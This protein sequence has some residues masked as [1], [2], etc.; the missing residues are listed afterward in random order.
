MKRAH[1]LIGLLLAAGCSRP[2]PAPPPAPGASTPAPH[3]DDDRAH[4]DLPRVIRLT[5]Q[6][7]KD[8]RVRVAP[9]ELG[10]LPETVTLNGRTA[11]DP[12]HVA[13]LGA[14]LS[15]RIE[16]VK[17]REGDPVKAGEALLVI[18]SPALARARAEYAAAAAKAGAA[19]ENARRLRALAAQRLGAAQDATAAAAE[20][21]AAEA[22]RDGL[23]QVIAGMGAPLRAGRDPAV[24]TIASP[25]AGQV[26]HRDAVAGQVVDAARTLMT[27]ADLS[28]VWFEAQLFEKDLAA[29]KEGA[30][31]EVRLN[32]YPDRVYT[33]KVARLSAEVD[34]RSH[35]LTARVVLDAPDANVRLGLFGTARISREAGRAAPR[36]RVPLSAV[37]EVGRKQVVFVRQPNGDYV[38]HAVTLGASA[39]GVVEVLAGLEKGEQVVVQ[40]VHTLK[41]A[42]LK[43]N[44]QDED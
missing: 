33:G 21:T 34:P 26:I 10:A 36:L 9:A 27:V 23:A 13:M 28:T 17:A 37:T 12:D 8:A 29:V 41:S 15:G 7:V 43:A 20:A 6:V 38:M 11:P 24:V 4:E 35:T 30:P 19:R 42:V 1:L 5:P 3:A 14:R 31:A 2:P 44:L 22:E 40:G 25:I 32:G 39:G 18:S 16:R